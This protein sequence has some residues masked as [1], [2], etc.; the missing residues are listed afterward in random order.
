M[1]VNGDRKNL[2][3]R[4]LADHVLIEDLAD[5]V[6]RRQLVP[7]GARGL[8]ARTF[9]ANDVVAKL[10]ALVADEHRGTGDQFAH[11]VLALAAE[12]AVKEL[13]ACGFVGHCLYQSTGRF[14][15]PVCREFDDIRS[16]YADHVLFC[17]T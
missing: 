12:R 4:F 14:K 6:R 11:L 1:V 17:K 16:L 13:V 10:D 3:R 2:F 8:A 15:R 7:I 5:L 9:L